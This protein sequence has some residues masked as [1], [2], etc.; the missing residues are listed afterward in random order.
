MDK[1]QAPDIKGWID[2]EN[3]LYI[4]FQS[5]DELLIFSARTSTFT[6]FLEIYKQAYPDKNGSGA[7]VAFFKFRAARLASQYKHILENTKLSNGV[8]LADHLRERMKR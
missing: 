4:D 1:P 3:G 8:T 5:V 6:I 2:R 7:T